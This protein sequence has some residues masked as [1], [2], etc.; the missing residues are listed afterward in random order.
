M[1]RLSSTI[2]VAAVLSILAVSTHAQSP[3]HTADFTGTYEFV[4]PLLAIGPCD[5]LINGKWEE[6]PECLASAVR[7]FFK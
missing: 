4:G 2:S 3:G 1:R 5:G 6:L 7:N